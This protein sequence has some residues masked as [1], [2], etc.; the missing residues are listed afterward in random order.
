MATYNNQTQFAS[1]DDA[2]RAVWNIVNDA[3]TPVN[4]IP[5]S[6]A[7]SQNNL[8]P[9]STL[10]NLNI[11]SQ[12][13]ANT[14]PNLAS[15]YQNLASGL[16]SYS[17]VANQIWDFYNT[18]ANQISQRESDYANAQYQLANQLNQ[19]LANQRDYIYSVFWPQWTLTSE[20][21]KYY[22][23]M[24]N[25]LA[26]EWGRQ[27]ANVAAQG[28]HSWA[29]LWLL[30]AQQN[31]AY[32]QAFENYLKVKEQEINAKQQIQSQLINYMTQL[33]QEYGNTTNQYILS[34]YQRANDLLNSLT[35]DLNNQYTN[36]ALARAQNSS[37]SSSSN[38]NVN[39]ILQSLLWNTQTTDNLTTSWGASWGASSNPVTSG[40]NLS[41]ANNQQ[42]QSQNP[43]IASRQVR[44]IWK[45]LLSMAVPL[46]W[47]YNL[48]RTLSNNNG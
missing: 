16:W 48:F 21:N 3:N 18:A 19:D 26:S 10:D 12:A 29:S 34:Q 24:W 15:A 7:Y 5:Q 11:Q 27:M 47:A 36:L 35:S 22:D 14:D 4:T 31:E 43:N 45:G 25:Y 23:D 13:W 6:T 28:I 42:S 1:G 38:N 44:D 33:R 8:Q 20:I 46:Y 37:S 2:L 17:N 32:N 30:R 41:S 9:F 40:I 39:N